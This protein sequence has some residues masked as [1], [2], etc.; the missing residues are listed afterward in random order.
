MSIAKFF[1]AYLDARL[2]L[3]EANAGS[4]QKIGV[5]HKGMLYCAQMGKDGIAGMAIGPNSDEV[6][7]VPA[8]PHDGEGVHAPS[9]PHEAPKK[10][11]RPA[12]TAEAPIAGPG[13]TEQPELVTITGAPVPPTV[14]I[15]PMSKDK[16]RAAARDIAAR[17]GIE[18]TKAI[19]GCP[20]DELPADQYAD[21]LAKLE[22]ANK[23]V[24]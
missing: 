10:R 2:A 23:E 21:R 6:P 11:G 16:F 5:V 8:A 13:S 19:I 14:Q 24:L 7:P 4:D 12:K 9:A 15:V 20:I 18:P 22:A 1:H 3:I 17:I